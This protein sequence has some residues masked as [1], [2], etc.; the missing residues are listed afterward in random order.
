M[1]VRPI[2]DD[3]PRVVPY[4]IVDGAEAAL[5]F[6]REVLGATERLRF[7]GADG[8]IGHAELEIGD[9]LIMVADAFPDMDIRDPRA[10]GGTPVSLSVYVED[11]DAVFADAL[12]HGAVERQPV[13]DKFYGDRA[14]Q[15]EDP[16]GHRWNVMTHVRD[17]SPAEMAQAAAELS[18]DGVGDADGSS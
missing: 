18:G 1:A 15:L 7:A 6:Y 17:V 3:Y 9:S 4:L 2:P 14:G 10:I 11:V 12:A 5:A 13:E 16:W 8:R